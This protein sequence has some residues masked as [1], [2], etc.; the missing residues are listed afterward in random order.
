MRIAWGLALIGA[1]AAAAV[2]AAGPVFAATPS[3]KP[4]RTLSSMQAAVDTKA[5][6]I[7]AKMQ[8][9]QAKVASKPHFAASKTILLA[10]IT[11]TVSDTAA[12]RKQ[13]DSATTKAGVI[14]ANPAH[15]AVKEDLA[16]LRA[17]LAAA[18]T[19]KPAQE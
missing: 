4:A 11:K 17:D 12:W 1:T 8:T 7:A 3:S 13:V 9:V 6:H 16:K 10:D 14:A 2:A 18:K 19:A 15:Q 5:Q